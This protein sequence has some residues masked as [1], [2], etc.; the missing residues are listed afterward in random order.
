MGQQKKTV[1][2]YE[3]FVEIYTVINKSVVAIL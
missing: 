3:I 1:F 2:F